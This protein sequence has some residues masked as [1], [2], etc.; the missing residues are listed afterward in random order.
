MVDKQITV[1]F[2]LRY[3]NIVVGAVASSSGRFGEIVIEGTTATA[4][5][6]Y[7]YPRFA[8]PTTTTE[9]AY[10]AGTNTVWAKYS[11]TFKLSLPAT[12][13]KL[14]KISFKHGLENCTGEFWTTGIMIETG[15][16]ASDW[17][18]SPLDLQ[19]RLNSVEFKITDSEILST[20][21]SSDDYIALK[22]Q[23]S[24][25]AGAITSKVSQTEVNVSIANDK[26]I[27]D[28]RTTNELPSYYWTN[29]PRQTIEEFKTKAVIGVTG[30]SA[31]YGNLTTETPWS[32]SSGGAIKQTFAS[33]DGTFERRGTS[34][35]VWTAW[36]QIEDTVGS[37]AKINAFNT[38]TVVPL[39]TR[40]STAETKITPSAIVSTVTQST[41]YVGLVGRMDTAETKI[42]PTAITNTVTSSTTYINAMGAKVAT[43]AIISSINQTA[44][45]IK[46]SATKIDITGAVT[47]SS[48][49]TSTKGILSNS[50]G[51][52][53][54]DNPNFLDWTGTNPA[55]YSQTAVTGLT[56]VASGNGMG[57]AV[58]FAVTAGTN[59]YLTPT[60]I[61]T[62]PYYQY[63]V[64]DFIF[65]LTSGTIGGAGVMVRYNATSLID[66]NIPISSAM[67]TPV[68]NK[69]YTVTKVIKV[70]SATPTAG[71]TGYSVFPMGA[72]TALGA[73]TTKTIQFDSLKIR[74]ASE[75]EINAY[76]TGIN[77]TTNA[78]KW[79]TASTDATASLTKISDMSNDAILS[80]TEKT[81][82]K[83]EFEI[84]VG[85]KIPLETQATT[86]EI[87]TEK[88]AYTD[89]H[90]ALSNYINPLLVSMTS[91][92]A[93]VGVTF[94]NHFK[95]Y[96]VAKVN[97]IKKITDI[98]GSWK[99]TGKTTIDG[100]KIE[101]DSVTATQI[102]VTSLDALSAN[103]G[104]MTAGKI[105]TLQIAGG[106]S[107][108]IV[109]G[110]SI[111]NFEGRIDY[112][113]DSLRFQSDAST[114]LKVNKAGAS[115]TA[116]TD[117]TP[118]SIYQMY[119]A[120]SPA[121]AF[122]I[123]DSIYKHRMI[124]GGTARLKFLNSST[125]GIQV[126]NALD[127]GYVDV[128]ANNFTM[129]GKGDSVGE[130]QIASGSVSVTPVANTYTSVNVSFGK[131][132]RTIPHVTATAATTVPGTPGVAEV[133]VSN[134]TV[135]GCTLWIMRSNTVATIINYVALGL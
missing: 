81:T 52:I 98:T 2:W 84:I 128:Y 60:V 39:A 57:N 131:S 24:T 134:V 132:L 8:T 18:H 3:Q 121:I 11:A 116:T 109:F 90:L 72:F 26:Q 15:N 55:G 76:E 33:A 74:P 97:L 37:Q 95:T 100:G 115:G 28:T 70:A 80:P 20:V 68:L 14:S 133:T 96:Y 73:I 54:N 101:A 83:K 17:S 53:I 86:Y 44:E 77:V 93:I 118:Q 122:G 123:D 27:R 75:Q 78:T 36:V 25:T 62:H 112:T 49:D 129:I 32:D 127:T 103:L 106:V 88:T 56:K 114:Y 6:V 42:T 31:T 4:T 135:S 29:F 46:I 124:G 67:G 125:D 19:E 13:T 23:S 94:R 22:A 10:I 38:S 47:F 12:A 65:N 58:Q 9:V 1:S 71:F 120:G 16:K 64:V 113:G 99:K 59:S 92:S 40:V 102:S 85:E 48:F 111:V 89:A 61:T 126:R 35:T 91:N 110:D 21:T 108:Q 69:W 82:V 107:N 5:K 45:A 105:Q 34:T 30:G 79:N 50:N 41:D 119:L 7:S 87:T 43:N 104:T 51:A 63:L 117:V 130:N 66:N